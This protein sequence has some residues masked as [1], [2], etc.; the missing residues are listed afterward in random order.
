MAATPLRHEIHAARV[1][2]T[3]D[4]SEF[5]ESLH[6]GFERASQVGATS[7]HYFSLGGYTIEL[8]F[9]SSLLASRILPALL[10]LAVPRAVPA[11]TV[12]L[13]ESA[14]ARIALPHQAA[15]LVLAA[16]TNWVG[17]LGPRG[18]LVAYP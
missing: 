1:Q 18:E 8:R 5:F 12:C 11:L 6:E 10:H 4:G 2:R 16:V 13:W 7:D 9:A 3:W 14:P 17:V 15:E